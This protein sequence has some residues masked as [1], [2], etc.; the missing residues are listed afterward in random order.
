[1]LVVETIARIR[2]DHL[3]RGVPIKQIARDLKLSRNT[4]RKVVRS[5]ETSLRYER[6]VQP[7]P[8][9]GP[10]VEELDRLL[11]AN[12]DKRRRDRLSLVR[13]Y[14]ELAGL[15]YDGGYDAVRRYAASWRRKR[16]GSAGQAYVPLT[17]DPGEAYQ[18]DW[19][20]EYAVIAGATVRVKAAHLRLCHSRLFL[21]QIF[22][23]RGPG[24]GV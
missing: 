8:K 14:E 13:I 19:S 5:D 11:E 2:R 1:M 21:V 24:D 17:F 9:L 15:G 22:S 18:F 16:S 10:W 12:E 23:A 3:G 6:S 7:L 20:H 4:V